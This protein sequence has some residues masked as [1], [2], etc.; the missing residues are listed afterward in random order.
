MM[1]NNTMSTSI[2]NEINSNI[3][4]PSS[5]PYAYPLTSIPRQRK[6]YP[7]LWPQYNA[8]QTNEKILF[9]DILGELCSFFVEEMNRKNKVGRPK[10]SR[11]DIIFCMIAKLYE[12][13][14]SRRLLSDLK[15]AQSKGYISKVPHFN[16]VLNY[17]N[18]PFI[19]PLLV[20]LIHASSLPLNKLEDTFAVDATGLSSAF[21]SRWMDYRFGSN[22]EKEEERA[23]QWLKVNLICGTKTHIVTH[24]VVTDGNKHE[25]P[26]FSEL[27]N[28]TAKNGFTI[29][30]I[31]ADK[32]YSSR[33][34]V[35]AVFELGGVPLIPFKSNAIAKPK[36][37]SAWKKS[38]IYF[39]SNPEE[40]MARYHK[41]SNVES[42]FSMLKRKLNSKLMMKHD[43]AQTN[44]ALALVLCHNIC[45][46]VHEIYE[47]GLDVEFDKSAHLL[48]NL[49]KNARI[50]PN[51]R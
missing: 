18:D 35:Q 21:Y 9:L 33:Q 5:A 47:A 45:C 29:S 38:F 11:T 43:L 30:E 23:K 28:Q 46:L 3:E 16:T 41:R 50:I 49:H 1:Y 32:G 8:A 15:I 20:A 37:C 27:V 31:S 40:F 48:Q 44:E 51:Y 26:Y 17:F 24:V 13:L 34:N 39:Q 22:K 6:I 2:I 7:Q 12:K 25:S 42:T 4:E 19:T 36:G 10:Y 14:S